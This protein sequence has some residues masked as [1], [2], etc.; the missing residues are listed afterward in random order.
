MRSLVTFVS[1]ILLSVAFAL[2]AQAFDF[3]ADEELH[4]LVDVELKGAEGEE[5]TLGF[6][7]TMHNFLLPYALS[8]DGYVLLVRGES[9]KFYDLEQERVAAWQ[10]AGF[11]PAPLPEYEVPLKERIF[12]FALYAALVLA[13]LVYAIPEIR[14]RRAKKLLAAAKQS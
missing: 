2:P 8:D 9:D 6:K 14:K 7:T 1:A 5:L 3:G 10:D 13:L 12:S 4:P 11:L